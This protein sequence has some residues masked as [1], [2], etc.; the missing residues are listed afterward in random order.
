MIE[1]NKKILKEVY[2]P[3]PADAKKYDFGLLLVIGGSE[4][5]SGSPALSALAAF[6]AGVDMV[7]IIAPKRAA[8]IIASFKPDLAA[9]PLK[10]DWLTKEHLSTLI[11]MTESAKAVSHGKVAVVIGGG[12]GRTAETQETIL[13]YLS[14]ISVPA[15]IDADAIDALAKNPQIVSGKPFLITPH[16]YEFFLLTKKEVRNLPDEEKINLVKSEA[17]RLNTTIMLKGK[18]DIISNGKEVALNRTGTPFM[19]KGGTGD[20][21]AG[22]AGAILARGNDI[23]TSAQAAAYINGMA[24]QMVASKLEDSMLATDLIEQISEVIK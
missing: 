22:I 21:L 15:V 2:K 9:Y 8:D 20:T 16:T 10:G 6:K 13:E 23:F 12:A 1:V 14:E 11:S 5:Y 17:E 19:T 7:K 3:R 18:I 4:F 24:G